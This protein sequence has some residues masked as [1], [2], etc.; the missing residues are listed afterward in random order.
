MRGSG[1]TDGYIAAY[2][3][4]LCICFLITLG[5]GIASLTIKNKRAP[6]RKIWR[7][8]GWTLAWVSFLLYVSESLGPN[9][10]VVFLGPKSRLGSGR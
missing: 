5:V 4:I 2:F 8:Y 1:F 7:W 9:P 3:A 10:P 6:G